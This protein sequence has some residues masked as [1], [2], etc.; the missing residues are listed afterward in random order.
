MEVSRSKSVVQSTL[1]NSLSLFRAFFVD[2]GRGGGGASPGPQAPCMIRPCFIWCRPIQHI[3]HS[4]FNAFQLDLGLTAI[5]VKV[6]FVKVCTYAF[7]TSFLA[8]E[9]MIGWLAT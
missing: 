4:C 2:E 9:V 3:S 8:F 1:G 5:I 6:Y 7:I